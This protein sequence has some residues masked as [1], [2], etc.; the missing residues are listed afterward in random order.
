MYKA[1]QI[2]PY[3]SFN[4]QKIFLACDCIEHKLAIYVQRQMQWNL[5]N[6]E[7]DCLQV[8][9]KLIY[10]YLKFKHDILNFKCTLFEFNRKVIWNQLRTEICNKEKLKVQQCVIL[11]RLHH[12]LWLLRAVKFAKMQSRYLRCKTSNIVFTGFKISFKCNYWS[13]ESQKY[14]K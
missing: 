14:V 13:T 7:R 8:Q 12:H 4:H 11:C 5:L 6:K 9:I 10:S 1:F 2:L 3:V